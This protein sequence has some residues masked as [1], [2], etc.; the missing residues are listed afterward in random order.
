M[1][2]QGQ[3]APGARGDDDDSGGRAAH[4]VFVPLMAQGHLIPAVDTAL[5]LATHGA[6]GRAHDY[7]RGYSKFPKA[8]FF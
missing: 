8:K 4:F 6:Q 2:S 3:P 7:K 5:L 1:G